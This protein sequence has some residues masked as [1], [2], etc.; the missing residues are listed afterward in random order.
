MPL[1]APPAGALA[2]K[3]FVW[4]A[5]RPITRVCGAAGLPNSF[6]PTSAPGRFRPFA[7]GA[8]N[9]VPTL[10]GANRVEGA[11][12]ES[13]FHDVPVGG[14]GWVIPRAS[15]YF[16]VRSI[17]IPQRDLRL[18]DLTGW[19]HKALAVD[20]RAL[21]EC[22]PSDYPTTA[23]WAKRFHE[24]DE[25]THGLYWRSRQF[26]KAV[27]V[28]LFGDRVREDELRVVYDETIGLWQGEGLDDVLA[29]AEHAGITIA[30]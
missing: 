29:A 9:T 1:P 18:V 30:F 21:V 5:Q 11:L 24:A 27:A 16:K 10:Y 2:L 15:L 23:M 22:D 26:D 3:Y 17:L 6:N 8:G 25:A 13:I 7:G 20:G 12:G 19:A 28:M 4:T 14:A